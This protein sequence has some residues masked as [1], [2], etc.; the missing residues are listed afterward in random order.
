MFQQKKQNLIGFSTWKPNKLTMKHHS[1]LF[2][3]SRFIPIMSNIVISD[4][5][6][7]QIVFQDS[8]KIDFKL[9]AHVLLN[10]LFTFPSNIT[11][12]SNYSVNTD[13]MRTIKNKIRITHHCV[14]CIS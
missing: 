1:V 14:L 8:Y 4:L 12:N 13:G 10:D 3:L 9:N 11:N 7:L 6:L 2:L 5:F